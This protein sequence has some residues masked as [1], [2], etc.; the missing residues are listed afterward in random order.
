MPPAD[1]RPHAGHRR[2][3]IQTPA[4][5][6]KK[7][8][9]GNLSIFSSF[10][11]LQYRG[12]IAMADWQSS[13]QK[14]FQPGKARHWDPLPL[15]CLLATLAPTPG[16]NYKSPILFFLAMPSPQRVGLHHIVHHS[17]RAGCGWVGPPFIPN[18][19]RGGRWLGMSP[20]VPVSVAVAIA[21]CAD[22]KMVVIWLVPT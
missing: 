9:N 12:V 7:I 5:Q 10:T 18:A 11:W 3:V 4:T 13:P 20:S 19:Y 16:N 15:L 2:Y 17:P 22:V 21:T 14:R 6:P 8:S 1:S